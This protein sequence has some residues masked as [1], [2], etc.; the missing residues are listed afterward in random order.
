MII[1][2]RA[3]ILNVV[4]MNSG[5]TVTNHA[6]RQNHATQRLVQVSHCGNNLCMSPLSSR[7]L[8]ITNFNLDSQEVIPNPQ[9]HNATIPHTH[10]PTLPQT[11][12]PTIPQ[13]TPTIPQSTRTTRKPNSKFCILK[14][15]WS[16]IGDVSV[17]VEQSARHNYYLQQLELLGYS[18]F[19]S[20]TNSVDH[21]HYLQ[22]YS[23]DLFYYTYPDH[24]NG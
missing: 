4:V 19:C 18:V 23:L 10:N 12:N 20:T 21:E 6:D 15:Y 11:H 13:S 7:R 14:S 16:F 1:H 24:F 22:I 17:T 3:M 8:P 9:C 2:K 5:C